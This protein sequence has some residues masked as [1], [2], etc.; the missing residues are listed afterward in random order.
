MHQVFTEITSTL[1][2]LFSKKRCLLLI[3]HLLHARN[4]PMKSIATCLGEIILSTKHAW[5]KSYIS[6]ISINWH[7]IF[8]YLEKKGQNKNWS[9]LCSLCCIVLTKNQLCHL[10]NWKKVWYSFTNWNHFCCLRKMF[11]KQKVVLEII[12]IE[13]FSWQKFHKDI[14]LHKKMSIWDK[15]L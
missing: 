6:F 9:E 14:C 3:L 15:S 1:Q 2:K 13:L 4:I 12:A 8:S 7:R 11:C 5:S 10:I